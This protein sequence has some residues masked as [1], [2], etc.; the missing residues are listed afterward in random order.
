MAIILV[1]PEARVSI[2]PRL[3]TEI[4]RTAVANDVANIPA[5]T[6]ECSAV[7]NEGIESGSGR[8]NIIVI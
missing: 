4:E 6:K 2:A 1:L 3:A 7:D 8:E 5:V